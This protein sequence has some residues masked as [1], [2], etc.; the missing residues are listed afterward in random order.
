MKLIS[1]S[2]LISSNLTPRVLSEL[3]LKISPSFFREFCIKL[4]LRVYIPQKC[5][6]AG[7][8]CINCQQ[9]NVY[10]QNSALLFFCKFCVKPIS[11]FQRKFCIKLHPKGPYFFF[12]WKS[13]RPLT[14]S[15]SDIIVFFFPKTRK[16][17][18][19]VFFFF[20]QK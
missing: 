16:K 2:I 3:C 18:I 14:H 12:P 8:L 11:R 13:L 1:P 15:I 9:V 7:I 6:S 4:P 5:L 17:K 20:S 19:Q 10:L